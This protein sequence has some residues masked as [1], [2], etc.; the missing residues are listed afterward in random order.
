MEEIFTFVTPHFGYVFDIESAMKVVEEHGKLT[1]TE[2]KL[3]LNDSNFGSTSWHFDEKSIK[4]NDHSSPSDRRLEFEGLP[5]IELGSRVLQCCT[6]SHNEIN[7]NPD[8]NDSIDDIICCTA[9]INMREVVSFPDYELIELSEKSKSACIKDLL[10]NI[11]TGNVHAERRVYVVFPS[12]AEHSTNFSQDIIITQSI[13]EVIHVENQELDSDLGTRIILSE[14]QLDDQPI[15]VSVNFPVTFDDPIKNVPKAIPYTPSERPS[16]PHCLVCNVRIRVP[17]SAILDIFSEA[18]VTSH[19]QIQLDHYLGTLTQATLTRHSVHS[20]IICRRCFQLCDDLDQLEEEVDLKKLKVYNRFQRTQEAIKATQNNN[21]GISSTVFK[22]ITGAVQN[23]D[24]D[25][26]PFQSSGRGRPHSRGRGRPPGSRG[27]GGRGPLHSIDTFG[28]LH[29]T[30]SVVSRPSRGRGRPRGRPPLTLTTSPRNENTSQG[31]FV[32]VIKKDVTEVKLNQ[33]IGNNDSNKFILNIK[34]ELP[35][36]PIATITSSLNPRVN[37]EKKSILTENKGC[38]EYNIKDRP[39]DSIKTVSTST[40]RATTEGITVTEGRNETNESIITASFETSIDDFLH[41]EED[42]QMNGE[43]TIELRE[44]D[45][46]EEIGEDNLWFCPT[47]PNKT[48]FRSKV[49]LRNHLKLHRTQED[50]VSHVCD[51]CGKCFST[52][53]NLRNHRKLHGARSRQFSCDSCD[54]SFYSRHHLSSHIASVHEGK[55][56]FACGVCGKHLSTLKTLEIHTLTHTGEKPYQCE[57]CGSQF[58]QR[59]NLQTHIRSTHWQEKR[60]RCNECGKAFTRKRLLTYHINSVHLQKRPYKCEL[61]NATFVYPHYYKRHLRK[62]TGEKPYKCTTCGKSFNSRENC[63][64]H[65]FTHTDMKPYECKLCGAGFMRKPLLYSHIQ[66]HHGNLDNIMQIMKF[67]TLKGIKT[68]VKEFDDLGISE[69]S[70]EVIATDLD[71]ME[72]AESIGTDVRLSESIRLAERMAEG[73]RLEESRL[74]EGVR[75]EEGIRLA[76][77]EEGSSAS[78][79]VVGTGDAGEPVEGKVVKVLP[80]QGYIIQA[81]D[82]TRYIIHTAG[83]DTPIEGVTNLFAELQGQV[84]EVSTHD[85]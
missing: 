1:N 31:K 22:K 9:R 59:S 53:Y 46:T 78:I 55:Q 68:E 23:D 28:A 44:D 49:A 63:N 51:V 25:Y 56:A 80:R 83:P 32:Q 57:I 64:A 67:N 72:V 29:T 70:V 50:Y 66:S 15:K 41:V 71:V 12:S 74:V 48:N 39:K 17:A 18:A 36:T 62:H 81:S 33:G 42:D 84:V 30:T 76:D 20:T 14:V 65:M 75:L 27:R 61:C 35:I 40:T 24:K 26:S 69:P 54:K 13:E 45:G 79:Q 4:W 85:C 38:L 8:Q 6:P 73:V 58:R 60:Y 2:Y 19:R 43:I 82:N 11:T 52:K 47:C 77:D 7:S 16:T 37:V 10:R 5:F 34:Q 3:L 21:S